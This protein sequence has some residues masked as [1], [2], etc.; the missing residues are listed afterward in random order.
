M[1]FRF[2]VTMRAAP[3]LTSNP[4][5]ANISTYSYSGAVTK[6]TTALTTAVASADKILV[7]P[8]WTGGLTAG[9]GVVMDASTGSFVFSAEL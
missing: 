8:S 2:P 6:G 3:T 9:L 5:L 1:Y 7:T 4:S